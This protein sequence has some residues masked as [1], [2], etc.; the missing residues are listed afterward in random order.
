MHLPFFEPL[1][2]TLLKLSI[3]KQ[4][5]KLDPCIH[6]E[7][8]LFEKCLNRYIYIVQALKKKNRE[9]LG[10]TELGAGDQTALPYLTRNADMRKNVTR[11]T[12]I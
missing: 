11:Q 3:F 10:G 1:Y 8:R 6:D 4:C 7:V 9:A 12:S 2:K 5:S